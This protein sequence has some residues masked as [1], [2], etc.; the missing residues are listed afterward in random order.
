MLWFRRSE[1]D[2]YADFRC[3]SSIRGGFQWEELCEVEI[4]IPSI[5]KQKEIVA[6]YQAV[7][8]KIKVNEKICEKLEATAQ[9]L[10]KHWFVDFDNTETVYL[11][12]YIETNPNL[13]LK[14]GEIANYTEMSDL[15]ENRLSIK[16]PIK[17]AY[18]GGARFQNNDTLLA[19]IT[20]CLENGKTGFVDYLEDKEIAFGSTEFIVVRPKSFVSQYWIYCLC[21]D[22]NFRSF[23]I[24]SMIGS[25]GRQRV[26]ESYLL[27][28]KYPMIDINNM[29][30]FH[31][32]AKLI[33]EEIK[34]LNSQNP[35]LTQLQNLLLSRLARSEEGKSNKY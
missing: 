33:F 12:E 13:S 1:F 10:Y 35:K 15:S 21:K 7:E 11:S 4:P 3:D 9:A 28:Y 18:S 2:R 5:E 26:H 22:E 25:S 31:S 16:L 30:K 17:R 23:A 14:K 19:R 32:S 24:S 6:Q 34:I 20:P 29:N 27:K 8:N